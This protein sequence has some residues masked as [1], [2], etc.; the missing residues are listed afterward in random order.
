MFITGAPMLGA[1]GKNYRANFVHA[2]FPNKSALSAFTLE[3]RSFP[4]CG[5][6]LVL[7]P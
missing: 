3:A 4:A 2:P 5:K 6:S 1:D 7:R